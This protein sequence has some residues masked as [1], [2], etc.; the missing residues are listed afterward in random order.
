MFLHRKLSYL[1]VSGCNVLLLIFVLVLIAPA[2]T[3]QRRS[4]NDSRPPNNVIIILADDL[5]WG[6]LSCYGHKR[7]RTPHLDRM[8]AEGARLTNFYSTAPNCTP[9]RAAL[10][11]GRYQFRSRLGGVLNPSSMTGIPDQETTLGEA[12]KSAGYMTAILGKW[13][14]GHL[15][16]FLPTRHGYD[17]YFGIPYSNDMVPV[18]LYEGDRVIEEKVQQETLTKR[19]TERAIEFIRANSKRPFFL[20]LAHTM[21]HKPLAA[22]P[23][24][25]GKSKAGLYGDTLAE[26][27]WSIGQVL[28]TL[29]DL[30]LDKNTLVLFSSDNGAWY[31]GSNGGLRGMK[32]T[33]Y[34]GGIRVPLIARFPAKIRARQVSSE[35]AMMADLYPTVLAAAGIAVP[36]DRVLDGKDIMP[37]LAEK[38]RSPHEA[39]FTF[40]RGRVSTVRAGKWKLHTA[41]PDPNGFEVRIF[42]PG[43]TYVDPV[44]PDGVRIIAPVK[45]QAHGSEFPGVR[46]GDTVNE[47]S[48][49]DMEADP[50]EQHDVADKHPE[51]VERLRGYFYQMKK[52][53][54]P[55]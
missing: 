21:P 49:F 20:Y 52:Q 9:S 42:K 5:G 1:I 13:H 44:A 19:Y 26:L 16:Q 4:E 18:N 45:G 51:V 36:R 55:K 27:D 47:F 7:F 25:Q 32:N 12:F 30:G 24:F 48:L 23:K 31:G 3:S 17:S 35:L 6:D 11:T 2:S 46:G 39:I 34:D 53:M 41:A 43:D 38:G 8:A 14:L 33:T 37:L 29:R 15:P 28:K 50:S 10:Q 54:N 22:S 40:N